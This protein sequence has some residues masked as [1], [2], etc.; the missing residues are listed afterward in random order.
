MLMPN[1][2]LATVPA[3]PRTLRATKPLVLKTSPGSQRSIV[4]V[5]RMVDDGVIDVHGGSEIR[6]VRWRQP[7]AWI[8]SA[9]HQVLV[10]RLRTVVGM[11]V[12]QGELREEHVGAANE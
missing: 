8:G 9:L 6:R 10:G 7:E 2:E 11:D 3:G 5:S 12:M 1:G 4:S